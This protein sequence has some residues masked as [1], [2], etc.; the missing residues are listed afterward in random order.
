MFQETKMNMIV[1]S[2]EEAKISQNHQIFSFLPENFKLPDETGVSFMQLKY[3]MKPELNKE[4]NCEA[5][6]LQCTI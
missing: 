1:L 5:K 4:Q 3:V 6:L 2:S